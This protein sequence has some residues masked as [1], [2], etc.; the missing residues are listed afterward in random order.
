MHLTGLAQR[1]GTP[2]GGFGVNGRLSAGP[3][4]SFAEGTATWVADST[5]LELLAQTAESD[6]LI[7]LRWMPG[8]VLDRR[9]GQDGKLLQPLGFRMT[10]AGAT[11]DR[12]LVAGMQGR[13][14]EVAAFRAD[15][16]ADETFGDAGRSRLAVEGGRAAI[17]RLCYTPDGGVLLGG[18]LWHPAKEGSSLGLWRLS[19]DG[20]LLRTWGKGGNLRLDAGGDDVLTDIQTDAQGRIWLLAH[21]RKDET[22]S[23]VVMRLD[24][25][26]RPDPTWGRM[27]QTTLQP[28]PN[29]A[30]ATRLV[31]K[32]D[33]G[34][35]VAGHARTTE[36]IGGIDWV[37]FSLDAT[38][39][40]NTCFGQAGRC[41][42]DLGGSDYLADAALQPDGNLLLAG[43][44]TYKPVVMR[45]DERGVADAA[46][47]EQGIVRIH[48][49]GNSQDHVR[50]L[51]VQRD[52]SIVLTGAWHGDLRAMRFFGNP[53]LYRLSDLLNAQSSRR[54]PLGMGKVLQASAGS[55]QA[56][57]GSGTHP[58]YASRT[59]AVDTYWN[60]HLGEAWQVSWVQDEKNRIHLYL[61]HKYRRTLPARQQIATR[62]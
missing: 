4:T 26:G 16:R 28:G 60:I 39:R 61:N 50:Q 43:T 38:G 44:S 24:A 62:R 37:V 58:G 49:S 45:I 29:L 27:G 48:E 21:T 53:D 54:L 47:G 7:W 46:F 18:Q 5:R 20:R 10:V 59:L 52:G 51:L 8:G 41:T 57:P 14:L 22:Y 30:R 34:V 15:G 9:F 23:F 2:D 33:G 31:R 40:P 3:T 13:Y 55:G 6:E 36:G 35:L 1:T 11:D 42:I 25:Q 17:D 56:L 32:P 12:R 19:P